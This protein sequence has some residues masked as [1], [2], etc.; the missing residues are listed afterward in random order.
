MVLILDKLFLSRTL[1]ILNL[2]DSIHGMQKIF[3]LY[4]WR[5]K[6][7]DNCNMTMKYACYGEEMM[8]DKGFLHS[9]LEFPPFILLFSFCHRNSVLPYLCNTRNGK[10]TIFLLAEIMRVCNRTKNTLLRMLLKSIPSFVIHL[11]EG[12][13]TINRVCL[14]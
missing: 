13:D 1:A 14:H 10:I 11:Q 3:S 7:L 12:L 6:F 4:L 5:V 9:Q 8:P 2:I